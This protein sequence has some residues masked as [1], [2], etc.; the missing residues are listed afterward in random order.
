M[1]LAVRLKTLLLFAALAALGGC[2]S[3]GF[4]RAV[5]PEEM[6]LRDQIR[7]YY[8]EASAAFAAGNADMLANLYDPGIAR[9]MSRDQIHA[10][11]LDFFA[12][13]GPA[14]FKLLSIDYERVGH[15]SAVVTISYRVQ[16]RDGDGSF[17]GTER[18]ELAQRAGRQ[19]YI[20][21][22][23]KVAPGG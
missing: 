4:G 23:D 22:W 3:V 21:A 6:I 11:G 10:W 1:G 9:P 14:A 8:S 16:P 2:I 12:K 13:H 20:T 19:W 18:D 7:A 17:E 15:V 5:T